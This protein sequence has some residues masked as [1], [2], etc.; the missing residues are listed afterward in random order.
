MV[1]SQSIALS[2][3]L[4]DVTIHIQKLYKHYGNTIAIRG[5]NLDIHRGEL[6]GLIGAD[7]AGKTTTFNILGGVM[8]S[9]AGTAQI[10]E[11]PARDARNHTGYL[12]QQFSLYP[13]L[14]VNENIH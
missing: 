10:L 8:E 1:L 14:S 6:F 9:T 2:P 3:T 7:G 5:I 12:T 13:D 4:D 11:L